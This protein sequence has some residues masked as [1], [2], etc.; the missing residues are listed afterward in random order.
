MCDTHLL[1][2]LFF[3]NVVLAASNRDKQR[4]NV[5]LSADSLAAARRL[6]LNV[7]AISDAALSQAVKH[8]EAQAWAE[9]N[10]EAIEARRHWIE[11][12]GLPLDDL[13][14]LKTD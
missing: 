12:N 13:Q 5:T 9:E 11:R 4:T 14:V 6:A 8:A 10:R 1:C 2:V 7:S 3:G